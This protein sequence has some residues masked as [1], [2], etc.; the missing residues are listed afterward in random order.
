MSAYEAFFD[1]RTLWVRE[2]LV[3]ARLKD[4]RRDLDYAVAGSK[5]GEL[6]GEILKGF[7]AR[8]DAVLDDSLK[9]WLR[10][11]GQDDQQTRLPS[12]K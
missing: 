10:L 9:A 3:S 5:D 2:T 4:L 8:L 11:R 7:K 1:P 6:D 12:T